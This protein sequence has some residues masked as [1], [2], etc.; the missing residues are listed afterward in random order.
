MLPSTRRSLPLALCL[1]V[2]LLLAGSGAAGFQ[3][4][5]QNGTADVVQP[6]AAPGDLALPERVVLSGSETTGSAVVGP[7]VRASLDRSGSRLDGAYD[8]YLLQERLAQTANDTERSR[9][10]ADTVRGMNGSIHR[11]HAR[12]RTARLEYL[13]GDLSTRA[14]LAELRAINDEAEALRRLADD[15]DPIDTQSEGYVDRYAA[16]EASIELGTL[17]GDII[18]LRGPVRSQ[19]G[20]AMTAERAPRRVYVT[21][22][23]NGTI[24]STIDGTTYH[25]EAHRND[26]L[27]GG[28]QRGISPT[29]LADLTVE[30]LYPVYR[31]HY[32]FGA[33]GQGIS[34]QFYLILG[35]GA[36]NY[37][38][39]AL[40]SY[41]DAVS[42]TV[43]WEY[44]RMD[45]DSDLPLG[46][47]RTNASGDLSVS[48]RPTYATGPARVSVSDGAQ[49]AA[50]V[51]VSVNGTVVAETNAEGT[52]WVVVP[53]NGST[54]SVTAGGDSATVPVRW[55]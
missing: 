10:L 35:E 22:S 50:N 51:T 33:V 47:A 2:V 34:G 12:E 44:Q 41:V 32:D 30:E 25:R 18:A 31:S 17:R 20:G 46:T 3:S 37:E 7:D 9:I 15:I 1:V 19:V 29:E 11:L 53:T 13:R 23:E 8:R 38:H 43:F 26:L 45:L 49:A 48:V 52:A 55:E 4:A 28:S 16:S 42:Q 54:V 39:G 40:R 6:Q 21:A 14:Y 5:P 24:L 27:V 36:L